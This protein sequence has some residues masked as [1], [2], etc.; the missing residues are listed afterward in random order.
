MD[1]F[2]IGL[3][4]RFYAF[5]WKPSPRTDSFLHL[6]LRQPGQ[7]FCNCAVQLHYHDRHGRDPGSQPN[8]VQ[9]QNYLAATKRNWRGDGHW[10]S[11][12]MRNAYGIRALDG[13]SVLCCKKVWRK[14]TKY[15]LSPLIIAGQPCIIRIF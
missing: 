12:T 9:P 4:I 7:G 15:N 8:V 10:L 11:G 13:V 5:P 3:G 2:G 6:P 14:N 1:D